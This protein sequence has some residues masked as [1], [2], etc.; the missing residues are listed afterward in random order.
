MSLRSP[1]EIQL[2]GRLLSE[3]LEDHDTWLRSGCERGEQAK[4]AGE[5]LSYV[6]LAD[7]DLR[8]ADLARINLCGSDLSRARLNGAVLQDANFRH[9]SLNS[10]DLSDDADPITIRH[11]PLIGPV[12]TTTENMAVGGA[13]L[14]IAILP[15]DYPLDQ[16]AARCERI[17][18]E[19][20]GIAVFLCA[21]LALG[22]FWVLTTKDVE[23]LL[24]SKV[25]LVPFTD[26][27]ITTAMVYWLAPPQILLAFC[28]W[29]LLYLDRLW[30][31][32]SELPAF[33]PD[34]S[35]VGSRRA[36]WPFNLFAGRWMPQLEDET[37][38][39]R[40]ARIVRWLVAGGLFWATPVV[41]AAFWWRYLAVHEVWGTGL[42]TVTVCAAAGLAHSRSCSLART[43]QAPSPRPVGFRGFRRRAFLRAALLAIIPLATLSYVAVESPA[44]AVLPT[45]LEVRFQELS[46]KPPS[47]DGLDVGSVEGVD[48]RELDLRFADLSYCFLAAA[49][50]RRTR[51][52]GA[53]LAV[54]DL[55]RADLRDVDLRE[56]SLFSAE[57]EGAELDGADL[58][59]ANLR[60]AAGLTDSQLAG[61]TTNAATILPDGSRGPFRPG[62]DATTVDI[63]ECAHWR[64]EPETLSPTEI[65]RLLQT[66]PRS[67]ASPEPDL[68]PI[69]ELTPAPPASAPT[70]GDGQAAGE[71]EEQTGRSEP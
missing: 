58:R 66:A 59:G 27:P 17:A 65:E 30:G 4:L 45:H 42:Q 5:D 19:A 21:L 8:Q 62:V 20:R 37:T 50:L 46:R 52:A 33:S 67:P 10:A 68:N 70:Q 6:H 24:D 49:D 22:L 57:L 61:A 1:D 56:G 38:H 69:P 29:Q 34:G 55:R 64:P 35:S 39:S 18:R 14:T 25:F 44:A 9:A 16:L 32:A 54:S 15:G 63:V 31:V 71:V 48:L 40:W 28:W 60:C 43:F 41:V 47:W 13:D 53:S 23:L 51:L 7:C 36:L 3:I 26:V 12:P 11:S 2:N